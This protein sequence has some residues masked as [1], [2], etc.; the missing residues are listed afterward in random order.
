MIT[1]YQ[2]IW[3]RIPYIC[4]ETSRI[5]L[6]LWW[7]WI[8]PKRSALKPKVFFKTILQATTSAEPSPLNPQAFEFDYTLRSQLPPR[9]DGQNSGP[10]QLLLPSPTDL[11]SAEWSQITKQVHLFNPLSFYHNVDWIT[12]FSFASIPADSHHFGLFSFCFVLKLN[13]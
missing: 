8:L 6:D 2:M 13:F 10:I 12:T 11:P 9:V 7:Y 4:S 1:G 3:Q 5:R